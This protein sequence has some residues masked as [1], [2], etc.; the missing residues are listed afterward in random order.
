MR[1]WQVHSSSNYWISV[2]SSHQLGLNN[3][4]T[5][6]KPN[7]FHPCNIHHRSIVLRLCNWCGK[8][9]EFGLSLPLPSDQSGPLFL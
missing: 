5:K 8:M 4:L 2:S 1:I 7:T 6:L 9:N 3:H